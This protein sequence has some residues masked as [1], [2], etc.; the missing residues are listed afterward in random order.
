MPDIIE[1][2]QPA[3]S[4]GKEQQAAGVGI[5]LQISM[6]VLSFVLGHVLR[7]HKF[8]YLPEA[9]A[10]LLIGLLVGGFANISNRETSIR[11]W[12][13]FHEEF[14]FLFLLPPIIFQSG[15]SLAPKPFFSN[16]GAIITFA[17]LGTFIS[18]V[19]TG[20]LVYLGG[21]VFLMYSLPLIECMMFGSLI[22]A[23]DPVT[24]LSI[25]QELGT[26]MNLY[27]LVFGE[28]VL[29]DAMAISLY[30]TMS[31]VRSHATSGQNF[32]MLIISFLETFVGSMSS[33]VGVGFIS[34]LLFKYAG[35]DVD[36]L[37]NLECCLFVLFPYFSYM[38]AEGIGLSGIV[39]ILFTGIVMK[40]YSFSNLSESSQR[41]TAAFFHLISSLAE[42]FVFIYMG[43]D[44]A[45]EQH[46][47]SHIGF[48]FF[49]I[50][51]IV[52]ARAANVFSCAY[53]VNLIRP[54]H[55][56]IPMKHQQA[57]YSGLRGA[58]AFALALQS[59]HDLPEGHGQTIFT[60]TTAIV[61]LTVLLI[62]GSTGTLLEKLEVV[63]DVH[64]ASLGEG[65]QT[66]N[67]HT[68][69]SYEEGASSASRLK[70]RLQE[71][72]RSAAS[73]ST[74]D[75][76]YLTPFFTSQNDGDDD[77]EDEP[78]RARGDSFQRHG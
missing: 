20:L 35:L 27:A 10:S 8:Y 25:F 38:L 69:H 57:L 45:M 14:F 2:A 3:G 1:T 46:S 5:L 24:V 21:L 26:D 62:G 49:S 73:F 58:M 37:Q 6:L 60:A 55:R 56:Q 7:R 63:G 52:V 47:W 72:H 23:T 44:I 68:T 53:L 4:P 11:T 77:P 19:V 41:F 31:S 33:G 18:S 42:T 48:I 43:F 30:R 54:A 36:N 64:D 74:L 40:H 34:A 28:S 13:N 75:K 12:F 39:S 32:I 71:L 15:F 59:V 66:N 9:S 17:I 61:V 22:S 70:S 50:L 67:G 76:K 78:H 29:N 16:F 65:F 51:F